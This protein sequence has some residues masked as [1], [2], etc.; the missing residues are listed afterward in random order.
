MRA[1]RF[2][3]KC[4]CTMKWNTAQTVAHRSLFFQCCCRCCSIEANS[5]F[6]LKWWVSA[7][8]WHL[9]I[10]CDSMQ[11]RI[12]GNANF[13]ATQISQLQQQFCFNKAFVFVWWNMTFHEYEFHFR[14]QET[15]C[16]SAASS[17]IGRN[18]CLQVHRYLWLFCIHFPFS[19]I[20]FFSRSDRYRHETYIARI[21]TTKRCI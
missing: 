6:I 10:Q 3:L 20:G 5:T 11:H 2:W 12:T 8:E 4:I 17:L 13:N 7:C 21:K 18:K 1:W 14:L 19:F 9:C 15:A 16:C